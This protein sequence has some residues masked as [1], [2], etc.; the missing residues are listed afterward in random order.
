[1]AK[2][3]KSRQPRNEL[4]AEFLALSE[5]CPFDHCNP[6]DCPLFLVRKLKPR[7]RL[8]WFDGLGEADLTYLAAYHHVC[9]ATKLNLPSVPANG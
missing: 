3:I 1:M 5:A 4:R 8:R 6:H 9:L 7:D 2:S